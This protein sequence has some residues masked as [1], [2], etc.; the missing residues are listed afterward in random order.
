MERFEQHTGRAVSMPAA[1]V[2]T[3]VIMPKQFLT[4]IDRAGLARGVF[5][6]LRFDEQGH[7]RADYLLNHPQ[8]ADLSFLVVGP[9]FGCGS[10]RE[11]AVWGLQQYGIRAIVGST[12]GGIFADNALNNGLLLVSL[13][14]AQVAQVAARMQNGPRPMTIDLERQSLTIDDLVQTF[15]IEPGARR[16]LMQGLDKIGETLAAA[17]AIREFEAR[18]VASNPWLVSTR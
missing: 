7:P 1:N 10:S 14:V 11:H 2:D 13:P 5:H 18:H 15:E 6:N 8:C 12:Y 17:S 9:N 4:G 16:M 3:D